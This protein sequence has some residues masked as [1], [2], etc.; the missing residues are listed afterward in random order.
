MGL[1]VSQ[2][3]FGALMQEHGLIRRQQNCAIEKYKGSEKYIAENHCANKTTDN[4]VEMYNKKVLKL[5]KKTTC[6]TYMVRPTV[7]FKIIDA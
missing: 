4:C 1:S 5:T 6:T 2:G 7:H 3:H